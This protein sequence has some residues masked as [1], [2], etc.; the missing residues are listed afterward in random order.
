MSTVAN[1]STRTLRLAVVN[2]SHLVDEI[3]D[4]GAEV[5]TG[6]SIRTSAQLVRNELNSGERIDAIIVGDKP[7][8]GLRGWVSYVRQYVPTVVVKS[9]DG[10]DDVDVPQVKLP[11]ALDEVLQVAG[12]DVNSDTDAIL[13]VDPTAPKPVRPESSIPVARPSAPA[14]QATEP[15]PESVP[16]AG[17][18]RPMPEDHEP[19]PEA[20]AGMVEISDDPV[21]EQPTDE[22]ETAMQYEPEPPTTEMPSV[23]DDPPEVDRSQF[24]RQAQNDQQWSNAPQNPPPNQGGSIPAQWPGQQGGSLPQQWPDQP[25]QT[26]PPQQ[27]PQGWPGTPP[28]PSRPPQMPQQWQNQRPPQNGPTPDQWPMNGGGSIPAQWPNHPP[29][30]NVPQQAP[31][32][33]PGQQGQAPQQWQNPPEQQNVPNPGQWPSQP[34]QQ[35]QNQPDYRSAPPGQ[36][37]NQSQPVPQPAPVR[38]QAPQR[39]PARDD[40]MFFSASRAQSHAP[41]VIVGARKGGVGKTSTS[42]GIAQRGAECGLKTVLIDAN[43]GQGGSVSVRLR[44]HKE[45]HLPTIYDAA[46]S[47]NPRRSFLM[48]DEINEVRNR[49]DNL[50]DVAFSL[51]QAPTSQ[52]SSREVVT[53][54]IYL[55]VI[56]Y[57]QRHA[58]LVVVD[59]QIIESE[60][61]RPDSLFWD[62]LVPLIRNNEAWLVCVTEDDRESVKNTLETCRELSEGKQ[63]SRSHILTIFNLFDPGIVNTQSANKT[64]KAHSVPVGIIDR[65]DSIKKRFSAGYTPTSI[66]E[67]IPVLNNVLRHVTGD[68]QTFPRHEAVIERDDPTP[69]NRPQKKKPGFF[70]RLFG[71]K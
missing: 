21:I 69:Q 11:R 51:V 36:G 20:P 57:A 46:L 71:R 55:E 68:S 15:E 24:D 65:I 67:F 10:I 61:H 9:F 26:Q 19:E 58:D 32:G 39:P 1:S 44:I 38:Q 62:K 54:N 25:Q 30:Q 56:R 52:T 14:A 59:T 2:A 42:L 34:P 8:T 27:A 3:G 48:P 12:A 7:E 50:D 63:I 40:D 47:N 17:Q 28:P 45:R 22:T 5:I 70:A 35:W 4:S 31:Q 43:M 37:Y 60:A 29:Q 49:L 23:P 16:E 53:N 64:L 6:D 41:I 13:G 33:W 18:P 66:P